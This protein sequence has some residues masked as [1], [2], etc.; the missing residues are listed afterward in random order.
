MVLIQLLSGLEERIGGAV[1]RCMREIKR[2]Y[3]YP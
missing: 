1:R 2:V 3:L